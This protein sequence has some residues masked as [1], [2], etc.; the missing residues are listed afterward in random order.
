CNTGGAQIDIGY[1]ESCDSC[2]NACGSQASNTICVPPFTDKGAYKYACNC[3]LRESHYS[4]NYTGAASPTT[5]S[6]SFLPFSL[7]LSFVLN[8][9]FF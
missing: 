8:M 7:F 6:L 5:T 4:W 1:V 3:C 2:D 9:L